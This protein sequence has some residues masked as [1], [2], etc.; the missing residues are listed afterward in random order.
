ML[1]DNVTEFFDHF[2]HRSYP[3]IAL[4]DTLRDQSCFNVNP[5][6]KACRCF[7]IEN[8]ENRVWPAG[9]NHVPG[10]DLG[11]ALSGISGLI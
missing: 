2:Q 3:T 5:S 6:A 4:A 7:P 9:F 1:S 10:L 11:G 8:V